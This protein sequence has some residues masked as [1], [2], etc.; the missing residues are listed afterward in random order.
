MQNIIGGMQND[1]RRLERAFD[2]SVI[3]NFPSHEVES[4]ENT[5]DSSAAGCQEQSQPLYGMPIDRYPRQL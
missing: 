3:A 4:G 5:R 2:K 1:Y